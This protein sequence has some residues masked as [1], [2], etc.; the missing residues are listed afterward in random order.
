MPKLA[1]LFD[2]GQ[3]VLSTFDLDEVLQRILAIARDFFHLPNVAIL[4]LDR[5]A[6][7]LCVRS[8]IGWDIGKDKICLGEHEGI[9]G[10][11]VLKKQ[12][13]YAPDVAED[14]RYICSAQSTR[15]ELAIPLMV[16]DEVVGVLDCQSDRL[17]H[18]DQ[19]TIELLTLFSTQ[20]SIALQNA[21]LYSLERQRARQLEAIN[22]IAQ[23]STAVME[24]EDLLV[25][26]CVVIQKAFQV[27]HV[28]LL[29]RDD[30]DLVMR[31]HQGT[32]T[33]CVPSNGRFPASQ[34]P[35]S[36]VIAA[37]GTIV[38]KDL[39]NLPESLRLFRECASRMSI[40]LISFGQTLGV[41]TLHSTQPN[42]FR[43]SD[44]QSLESV[45][46]ICANSIQ[47]AHYVERVKQLAYLDGLTG[48]FN[49]RFFELRIIEEIER[50]RRYASGM[51]VIMADIDQFKR[52]NDEFGHLLGDEVLRQVSSLFHQQVR[53]VDVVC[54]YGGEEFAILLTQIST[55][56]AIAIAEKLRR[57]VAKFQF[58]GVPRTITISAGV[59][60][61]PLH[62][63]TRDEMVRAA[64]SG[65]YAA[66][67][68]GRNRVCV[69]SSVFTVA[70]GQ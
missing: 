66:K 5:E 28:S 21:R 27:A 17:D 63:K 42:A 67:Q 4:L 62:G 59:A 69:A 36:R 56:Q 50:A 7:Q 68:A 64:D 13:V 60:S 34:E 47:N 38:E 15:S 6:G 48:I 55:Q 65:L 14:P 31:A 52:L 29:L 53:K 22:T 58:P 33:P 9:T 2:A 12:P 11:S 61:F 19:E 43:E 1:V 45:A 25:R 41:L 35:W 49:R 24:L 70:S 44:L 3:A 23:Q 16:R 8:Q 37:S 30:G 57:L 39:S 18:F 10:A 20:A 40:P 54:R 26:V 51:A 46:D 32:L